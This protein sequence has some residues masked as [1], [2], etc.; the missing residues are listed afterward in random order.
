MSNLRVDSGSCLP[1]QHGCHARHRA[2]VESGEEDC[3][4]AVQVS[5]E[6]PPA[7]LAGEAAVNWNRESSVK[8]T[9]S[10]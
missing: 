3:I 10:K 9:G 2:V 8:N 1:A 6:I 5:R 4:Q 7:S